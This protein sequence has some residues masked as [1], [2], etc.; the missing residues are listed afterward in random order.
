MIDHGE[1]VNITAV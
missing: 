1:A